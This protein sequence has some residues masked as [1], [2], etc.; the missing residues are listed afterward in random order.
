MGMLRAA[1][2]ALQAIVAAQVNVSSG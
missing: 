1:G 2:M